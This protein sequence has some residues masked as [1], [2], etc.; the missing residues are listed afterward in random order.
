MISTASDFKMLDVFHEAAELGDSEVAT[1]MAIGLAYAT[2]TDPYTVLETIKSLG[3]EADKKMA[4]AIIKAVN[5][6]RS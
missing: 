2:K 4:S 1:S 5:D 3:H 6:V